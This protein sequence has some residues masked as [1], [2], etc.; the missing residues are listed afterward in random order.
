PASTREAMPRR[1]LPNAKARIPNP[2][3][4]AF[5]SSKP[6]PHVS[7][8]G[9]RDGPEAQYVGTV[10][11]SFP[12]IA[13][14]KSGGFVPPDP[15]GDVGPAQVLA[16]VNSRLRTLDKATGIPDDALDVDANL[17]FAPVRGGSTISDQ[18]VVYDRL[19]RRWLIVTITTS[20]PN[21]ILLAV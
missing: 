10:V 1:V 9:T 21:R 18:R 13:F 15:H 2:A 11:Q 6:N 17:F 8:P 12:G 7:S 3:S 20:F 4:P 16:A 19:T 14:A 5:P